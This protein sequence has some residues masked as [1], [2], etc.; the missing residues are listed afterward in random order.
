VV[1]LSYLDTPL[2]AL[3]ISQSCQVQLLD[4]DLIKKIRIGIAFNQDNAGRIFRLGDVLYSKGGIP[5][6]VSVFNGVE[7]INPQDLVKFNRPNIVQVCLD[8]TAVTSL[9]P[10]EEPFWRRLFGRHGSRETHSLTSDTV[11]LTDGTYFIRTTID[12]PV[13]REVRASDSDD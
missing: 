7:K 4:E 11:D 6:R 1:S 2:S 8:A 10:S 3:G 9:K 12:V 13:T 5:E